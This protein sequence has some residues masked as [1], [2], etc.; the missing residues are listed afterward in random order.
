LSKNKS[1]G[2]EIPALKVQSQTVTDNIKKADL[3]NNIFAKNSTQSDNVYSARFS[4]FNFVTDARFSLSK[5]EP[6]EVYLVLK[7]LQSNKSTPVGDIHNIFLKKCAL[8]LALP[9]TQFFNRIITDGNF[10]LIWKHAE[11]ITVFKKGDKSLPTNYRSISLL[12]S[13]SKVFECVL[14][15]KLMSY[16]NINQLLY[17][18]NSGFKKNFPHQP[19]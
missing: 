8:S 13:L 9:L 14:H 16:F 1:N 3:L 10:P 19:Y 6:H 4:N 12:P 17:P 7:H 15:T 5:F 2:I 18:R 11:V